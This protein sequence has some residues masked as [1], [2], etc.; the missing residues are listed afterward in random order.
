MDE[1]KDMVLLFALGAI[2]GL[3]VLLG[4]TLFG[5]NLA[6]RGRYILGDDDKPSGWLHDGSLY[7]PEWYATRSKT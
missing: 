4:H 5:D 1:G 6:E 2:F 7:L 3:G